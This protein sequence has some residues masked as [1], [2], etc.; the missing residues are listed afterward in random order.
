MIQRFWVPQGH[1][2]AVDDHGFLHDPESAV[3]SLWWR[4]AGAPLT[5]DDLRHYRSVVLLGEPGMGKSTFLN[6]T[7]PL[8]PESCESDEVYADLAGF[9]SEDR[10]VRSVFESTTVEQW[11]AGSGE[12][13]L[14]LDGFDDAQTRVPQLGVLVAQFLK[15]WPVDR[16]WLRIACRTSD[17][18]LSLAGELPRLVP[19]SKAVELLPLRRCDIAVLV[20]KNR[21]DPERFLAAVE[22]R[23][24]GALAARPLTL[25]FLLH[26]F[27]KHNQLP[28]RAG[29]LYRDNLLAMCDEHNPARHT[30][31][32]RTVS[33][34][35]LYAVARRVGAGLA[36]GGATAVWLG[37]VPCPTGEDLVTVDDLTDGSEPRG[38]EHVPV[39]RAMVREVTRT[40][41]FSSRG[42]ARMGWAHTT[43][44]DFL[45]TDWL[46]ANKLPNHQVRTLLLADDGGVRPQVRR[47]AAWAVALA[48]NQF[49]WLTEADPEAFVGEVDI[50]D[51]SLCQVLVD[52]LLKAAATDQLLNRYPATCSGL[53]HPGLA[54][55]LAPVLAEPGPARWLAIRIADDCNLAE[56]DHVLAAIVL[57]PDAPMD[58]RF[59]AGWALTKHEGAGDTLL[60]LVLDA[61]LRNEDDDHSLLSIGILA[62]WP[63]A[64]ST[65]QALDAITEASQ[66]DPRASFDG[67]LDEFLDE[68][69]DYDLEAAATWLSM[70]T[71]THLSDDGLLAKVWN[72]CLKL[73]A[74]YLDDPDAATA[75][76]AA[77]TARLLQHKRVLTDDESFPDDV[78]RQL[79]L[80]VASTTD[81]YAHP[82][83]VAMLVCDTEALLS[84]DDFLWLLDYAGTP[85]AA[86]DQA[87]H[88][89]LPRLV[90]PT[91]I[92]H[93][94]AVLGLDQT[95][96]LR[97]ALAYWLDTCDLT[98]PAVAEVRAHQRRIQEQQS[99]RENPQDGI[100]ERIVTHLDAFESG[101]PNGYWLA[102]RLVCVQPGT[103]FYH[104]KYQPDLTKHRRWELLSSSVHDRLVNLA[105]QYLTE[106]HCN[107][108]KW[109]GKGR[110]YFP[111][112][113]AYRALLLLLKLKPTALDTLP[114]KVWQEWAP[115]I[116]GWPTINAE[117]ESQD[118]K[119][120]VRYAIPQAHEQLRNALLAVIDGPMRAGPLRW[121]CRV[122]DLLWDEGLQEELTRRL[123]GQLS[124]DARGELAATLLRNAPDA[125]HTLLISWLD[126]EPDRSQF[127]AG[128]LLNHRAVQ[129]WPALH[130]WLQAHPNDAEKMFLN[131][132]PHSGLSPDLPVYAL[133]DLYLWLWDHFPPHEYP[134]EGMLGLTPRESVANFR[135]YVL[136]RL[137]Q[138][139]TNESLAA[140]RRIADTHPEATW[141]NRVYTGARATHRQKTWQP[142]PPTQLR[143]LAENNRRR[144]VRTERELLDAV[145][146]AFSNIQQRLVGETPESHLLWNTTPQRRPKSEDEISDY[147]RN[148]L[149]D[150]LASRHAIVNRE[151]QVRRNAPSGIGERTDLRIDAMTP[152]GTPVTV[153]VEVKNA[154][155][156]EVTTNLPTQLV[157]Q[158]MHDIG[159]TAGIY[160]VLWANPESWSDSA[161]TGKVNSIARAAM[162]EHL[163]QQAHEQA[164]HERDVRVVHLDISYLR[165]T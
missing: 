20:T 76:V 54:D 99:S 158:Y 30:A 16:L 149:T 53:A 121:S 23:H 147:L 89:L 9:G 116:V 38:S 49:K 44:Q 50:P 88:R 55:Q 18:P 48:P 127:A 28:E 74:D 118:Q 90:D 114:P 2:H 102:T 133:T 10:L 73:C 95:S 92:D 150:E 135:E 126:D 22:T 57:D 8:L 115:I 113:A 67:F 15:G 45:A 5:G 31:S 35:D 157:G 96:P 26:T 91:R 32:P 120:L 94:N 77:A 42:E 7:Q 66:H 25:T 68:L 103:T 108:E 152:G 162:V 129:A 78:R 46:L 145:I 29:D 40:P 52:Q 111:A 141:L 97:E 161:P 98:D 1:G 43:F 106:G 33:P 154:W 34:G 153:V 107:P 80:L 59:R 60:P 124:D 4:T 86:R 122:T 71:A 117:S 84:A 93:A 131:Q 63:H 155:N 36:F 130:A 12:L 58:D 69:T 85:E 72:A 112:E 51:P 81:T 165:P 75:A 14:I 110:R 82:D 62:S 123:T 61:E 143:L 159:T 87:I 132:G 144:L 70:N 79:A 136:G 134:Y 160:L 17:W 39:T 148:R 146:A 41:L 47:I 119:Y 164:D 101:D 138:V 65:A 3:G 37:T 19:E 137:E 6:Q 11:L 142:T 27:A 64:L 24:V 21:V 13:C 83:K 139:G 100:E 105:P 125:A 128:L 156:D 109:V 56:F 104:D 163:D 151:V 140:I